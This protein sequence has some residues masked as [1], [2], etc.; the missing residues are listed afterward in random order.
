MMVCTRDTGI[1]DVAYELSRW[2]SSWNTDRGSA[3]ANT[4]QEGFRSPFFRAGID[5]FSEGNI[6]DSD[7]RMKHHKDTDANWMMVRVAGLGK[8]LRIDL[9]EVL[10]RA[11]VMYQA[12][13][14]ACS[15]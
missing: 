3:V 10:V 14:S 4:S 15:R 5:L 11:E 2:P 13:Q 6:D 12:M 7:V 9:E 8:A 1:L